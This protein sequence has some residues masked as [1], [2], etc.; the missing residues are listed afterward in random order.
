MKQAPIAMLLLLIILALPVQ[1][2]AQS[3]K[4]VGLVVD[5]EMGDPIIGANVVIE[6]TK[7]G[8]A[9]DL[10]GMFIIKAVPVGNYTVK[11]SA[12][13]Y[14][15]QIFKDVEVTEYRTVTLD[16]LL[17]PSSV[18]MEEVAY[19]Y[20]K[21]AVGNNYVDTVDRYPNETVE[22]FRVE[23]D[24]STGSPYRTPG[25]IHRPD[26]KRYGEYSPR[27]NERFLEFEENKVQIPWLMPYSTFGIDVD[28]AGYALV[29]DYILDG[30]I[31]PKDVARVEQMVNAFDY[32]YDPPDEDLVA[33]HSVLAPCAWDSSR[34]LLQLGLKA[35]ET[36]EGAPPPAN[37]VLLID[38][39]GSMEPGDKMPLL[40]KVVPFL[41]DD[42]RKEDHLAIVTYGDEVKRRLDSTSGRFKKRILAEINQ[43]NAE[44][45]TPGGEGIQLAYETARKNFIEGGNNRVIL[46]TD[47]D[48][49]V[50]M[51][52]LDELGDLIEKERQG[53][54]Y[55]SVLGFGGGNI[56][57]DIMET[58]ADRG[59]GNYNYINDIRE[60][61]RVLSLDEGFLHAIGKD[62]KVQIEFNPVA[63]AAYRLLGYENRL[64]EKEDFTDDSKDAGE[65]GLGHEVTVFYEITLA[66]G[67]VRAE[68]DESR[69]LKRT[70]TGRAEKGKEIGFAKVRGKSVENGEMFEMGQ[71]ILNRV[72]P[73]SDTPDS[74]R[75]ASSVLEFTYILRDSPI[76]R[77]GS[78]ENVISLAKGAKGEDDDGA[79]AEF[80]RLA[81]SVDL[82]N[83]RSGGNEE[84]VDE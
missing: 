65:M 42:L 77:G 70:L 72:L 62:V 53:G 52:G 9:T 57:G 43:L 79:R 45:Y 15:T 58:L 6:G 5:K 64:L 51:T 33:L 4:V 30:Y 56:K 75:F 73:L 84:G 66:S 24:W 29:R 16:F 71:P 25:I 40:K 3:G 8:A 46:M 69:Y 59:D 7:L 17:I 1:G 41:V 60:G 32:N 35:R 63:V 37:F 38:V 44:G 2:F 14:A 10:E 82:M 76:A 55:L 23:A 11:A 81:E 50:G 28:Q 49:N 68:V 80:I 78:F 54:I 22:F 83:K 18:E 13:G 47:G 39:S 12:V 36:Y 67:D 26:S 31:P 61:E 34:Y 19:T 27:W 21:P 74:Y 48:F 20:K